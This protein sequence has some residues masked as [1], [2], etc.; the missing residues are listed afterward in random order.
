MTEHDMEN[1]LHNLEILELHSLHSY[2]CTFYNVKRNITC[3]NIRHQN[4]SCFPEK[5]EINIACK[6]KI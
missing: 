4:A 5:N 6:I 3:N 2:S 1:D